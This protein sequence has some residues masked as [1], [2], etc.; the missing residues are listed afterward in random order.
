[1]RSD[2]VAQRSVAP[3]LARVW[4]EINSA[5]FGAYGVLYLAAPD[6]ATNLVARAAIPNPTIAI[7][8]RAVYGG[9]SLGFAAFLLFL[10]RSGIEGQRAGLLGCALAFGGIA[11]GRLTGIIVTASP[12]PFMLTLLAGEVLFSALSAYLYA[13]LGKSA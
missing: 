12:L 2:R 6:F 11:L 8:V 10:D 9:M 7:D 4:L 13:R 1:M 5:L 3:R